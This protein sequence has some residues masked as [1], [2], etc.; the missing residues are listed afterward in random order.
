MFTHKYTCKSC[1]TNVTTAAANPMNPL[2]GKLA[3]HQDITNGAV[4]P[5]WGWIPHGVTGAR[6]GC[7]GALIYKGMDAMAPAAAAPAPKTAADASLEFCAKPGDK[8]T[9]CGGVDV[10]NP[11]TKR[12]GVN[13]HGK[14]RAS[15][16]ATLQAILSRVDALEGWSTTNCAEIDA[17]DRLLSAGVASASIR[18]HSRDKYGNVKPPCENCQGWLTAAE[19]SGQRRV[20]RLR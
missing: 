16:H 12:K 20:Y 15:L 1:N 8:N 5:G 19:G 9:I 10:H 14:A 18:L 17:A 6:A 4:H 2:S 13:A 7:Y 11:A 3:V